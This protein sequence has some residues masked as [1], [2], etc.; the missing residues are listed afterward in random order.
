VTRNAD[1]LLAFDFGLARIGVASGNRLTGTAT[2]VATL[3]AARRVPWD[4][5]DTVVKTWGPGRLVVGLPSEDET[6]PLVQ[7]I[8]GFTKTLHER[9]R[10]PVDTVD[11]SHTS[12]E[13][14]E[15]L[16][17][18]RASGARRRRVSRGT[19]DRHAACLIAVR[20]MQIAEHD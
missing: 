10:L 19:I 16:R 14:Q 4:E 2:P 5:I 17:T 18:E 7:R 9:Y 20:W 15:Q 11:E 12:V 8:R 13:A 1:L 6:N 3:Q